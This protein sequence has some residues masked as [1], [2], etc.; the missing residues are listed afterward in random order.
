MSS[1][2]LVLNS[3]SS[4]V[5]YQLLDM[6]DSSRLAVGLVERIGEETSRLKHTL[7]ATGETRGFEAAIP[8]HEAAL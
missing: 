7:V 1:R 4:S 6:S 5:K 8:D 3:G 2:V